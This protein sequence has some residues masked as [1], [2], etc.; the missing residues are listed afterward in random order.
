VAQLQGEIA[1]LLAQAEAPPA[2]EEI[3]PQVVVDADGSYLI[4]GAR[5]SQCASEPQRADG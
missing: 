4:L 3:D 5:V 2:G 1:E